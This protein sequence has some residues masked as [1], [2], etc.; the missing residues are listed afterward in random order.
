MRVLDENL[1]LLMSLA[2]FQASKMYE[3]GVVS[4]ERYVFSVRDI[5]GTDLL[6]ESIGIGKGKRDLSDRRAKKPVKKRILHPEYSSLNTEQ[7]IDLLNYQG[8]ELN[9]PKLSEVFW[10]AVWPRLL[11]RGWHSEKTINYAFQNSKRPSVF[12]PPGIQKFSRRALEKGVQYFE[13]FKDVLDK[14]A[15]EPELLE[16]DEAEPIPDSPVNSPV[17]QDDIQ[18]RIVDVSFAHEEDGIV[19]TTKLRSMMSDT[20]SDTEPTDHVQDSFSSCVSGETI[21]DYSNSPAATHDSDGGIV[22]HETLTNQPDHQLKDI[23]GA[24]TDQEVVPNARNRVPTA[25][26][27][28]AL[29]TGSMNPKKK[30]RDI[31]DE[32]PRQVRAK[33]ATDSGPTG[34]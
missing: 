13:S 2:L 4:F 29:S 12:L 19:K 17:R 15:S 16:P 9:T 21:Q 5:V 8:D 30:K 25:K 10:E 31:E 32:T 6:I 22:L 33:T 34:N 26:A 1:I 14:V 27:L 3:D 20:E 24:D 7:I 23:D 18:C 11:A 28:E